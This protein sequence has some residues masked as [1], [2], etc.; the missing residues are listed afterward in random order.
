MV[1]TITKGSAVRLLESH[2]HLPAGTVGLVN[3]VVHVDKT[4][5]WFM[6]STEFEIYILDVSRF[7]LI[8]EDEAM[9]MGFEE[10]IPEIPE[11]LQDVLTQDKEDVL[12]FTAE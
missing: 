12:A 2:E 3:T 10:L 8:P 11:D 7:E 9:E 5:V 6:P 4:Y 1:D